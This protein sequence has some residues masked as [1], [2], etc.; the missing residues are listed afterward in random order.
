MKE[1][2]VVELAKYIL[3]TKNN[4]PESDRKR[5]DLLCNPLEK[6][7][8]KEKCFLNFPI[9]ILWKITGACNCR[10]KHCWARG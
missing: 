3:V 6:I 10:C 2:E 9:R 4:N 8:E 1:E 5:Y 7:C